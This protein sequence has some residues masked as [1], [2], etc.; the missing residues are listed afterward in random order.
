MERN[1]AEMLVDLDNLETSLESSKSST[2]DVLKTRDMTELGV[3]SCSKCSV[4]RDPPT[5]LVKVSKVKEEAK[6]LTP[7][8]WKYRIP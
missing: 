2:D 4:S 7:I 3:P 5:K 8:L 1:L 6:S